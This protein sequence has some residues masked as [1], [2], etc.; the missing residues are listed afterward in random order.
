MVSEQDRAVCLTDLPGYRGRV[1]VVCNGVD[2]DHNRPG[3][4]QSQPDALVFNGALTYSANYA[5]M[6]WFLA[7]VYPRIKAQVPGVSLTITGSRT[8]V[9]LAGLALDD[10]VRL[11]GFVDDVR[12]PVAAAAVCVV[13]I[14]HGRRH[15]GLRSWKP[16]R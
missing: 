10:T 8:G 7:E 9:D 15:P 13:P 1:E 4:A 16:W 2:C 12:F 3:L 11:T 14:R 6:R 5:A